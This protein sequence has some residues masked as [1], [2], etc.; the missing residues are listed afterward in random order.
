MR[1]IAGYLTKNRSGKDQKIAQSTHENGYIKT[2]KTFWRNS[3]QLL[4]TIA[5]FMWS[6]GKLRTFNKTQKREAILYPQIENVSLILVSN[7]NRYCLVCQGR[8]FRLAESV[9][10]F[11]E[12]FAILFL[13]EIDRSFGVNTHIVYKLQCDRTTVAAFDRTST[14]NVDTSC[15]SNINSCIS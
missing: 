13:Y 2:R 9:S 1:K 6:I 14:Y 4:S 8:E 15:V 3:K 10:L 7:V 11:R 5:F 12:D